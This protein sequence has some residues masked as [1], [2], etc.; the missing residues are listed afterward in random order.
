[1]FL[2]LL[3]TVT[4]MILTSSLG[5]FIGLKLGKKIPEDKLKISAFLIFI[6]FGV[7]KLYASFLVQYS[8]VFT[9]TLL[10]VM[11]M[12]SLLTIKRFNVKYSLIEETSFMRQAEVLK[13][14]T[15]K[16]EFKIESM[17][18]GTDHCGV[19]DG[20]ACLVGYMR[21]LLS[22]AAHPISQEES[23]KIAGLKNK[24][25]DKAEAIMILKFLIEYYDNYP[26]EYTD[27]EQ[28]IKLRNTAEF[29]AFQHMI[30]EKDYKSYRKH[31]I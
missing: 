24:I 25:F 28:L 29:I 14:T 22:H 15:S 31:I 10:V 3:G 11:G 20:K 23:I 5:I 9:V 6:V 2:V 8:I 7:Q 13:Q 1:M 27:N 21:Y 4:G 16:I 18:K 30:D 17:C 12:V 19:C 26:K